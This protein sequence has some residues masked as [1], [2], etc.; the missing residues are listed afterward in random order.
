MFLRNGK[1]KL[2]L[3]AS[4]LSVSC[5]LTAHINTA[6]SV[7]ECTSIQGDKERLK[8][9]DNAI[10]N[11]SGSKK[12]AIKNSVET[13]RKKAIVPVSRAEE[14]ARWAYAKNL[15]R[16]FL[17]SGVNTDVF[18]REP[19]ST[20]L[21]LFGYMNK[22]IVYKLITE[23]MILVRAKELGFKKVQFRDKVANGAWFFDLSKPGPPPQ[24]DIV[25]RLCI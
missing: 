2:W 21:I 19:G 23:G 5:L 3:A 4:A 10:K 1:M 12:G 7:E 11:R 16:V 24:C 13:P 15:E 25:R 8:C 6:W 14:E 18:T 17:S 22:A 20:E 9:F